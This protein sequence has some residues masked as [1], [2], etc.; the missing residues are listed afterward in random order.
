EADG[1]ARSRPDII[2]GQRARYESGRRGNDSPD[3]DAALRV[4]DIDAE[5]RDVADIVLVA[6]AWAAERAIDRAR[7][8]EDEPE[9]ARDAARQRTDDNPRCLR[10]RR[11]E[12]RQ[13][14]AE[15]RGKGCGEAHSLEH[16]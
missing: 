1:R 14:T 8:A 13:R 10:L 11:C 5:L 6:P 16:S 4:T 15:R 9:T 2:A 3:D 12:Q 7:R